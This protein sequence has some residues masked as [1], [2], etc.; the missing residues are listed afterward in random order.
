MKMKKLRR[1]FVGILNTK[2][3]KFHFTNHI[4]LKLDDLGVILK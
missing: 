2:N 1:S 3:K 4:I